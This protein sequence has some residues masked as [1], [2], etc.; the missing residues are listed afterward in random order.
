MK[1]Y[2]CNTNNENCH[3]VA[4]PAVGNGGKYLKTACGILIRN[5]FRQH[6][7]ESP[8]EGLC[9]MCAN[10]SAIPD[11]AKEFIAQSQSRVPG[12]SSG[13]AVAM[14]RHVPGPIR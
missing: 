6:E 14:M 7:A 4:E 13:N 10:P 8:P 2:V 9:S 11:A 1:T 5:G 3:E 12:A